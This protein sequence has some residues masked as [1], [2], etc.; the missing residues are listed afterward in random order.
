MVF[1][2]LGAFGP[3]AA[4]AVPELEAAMDSPDPTTRVVAEAALATIVPGRHR[5]LSVTQ[6]PKP[7]QVVRFDCGD[8]RENTACWRCLD[9]LFLDRIK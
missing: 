6:E 8:D 1:L 7:N 9:R 5:G 2:T 4:K 3:S